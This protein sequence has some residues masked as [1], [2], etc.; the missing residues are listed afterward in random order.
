MRQL[1]EKLNLKVRSIVF[2]LQL[3]MLCLVSPTLSVAQDSDALCNDSR[4]QWEQSLQ[5]LKDGLSAFSAIQQTPA[6]QVVRRPLVDTR[7]AKSIALQI[8]EALQ[9]KEE[10]LNAKRKECRAALEKE[11]QTYTEYQNCLSQRGSKIK[12][13]EGSKLQKQRKA[14]VDKAL[15]TLAEVREVQGEDR[16]YAYDAMRQYQNPYGQRAN[17]YWQMYQGWWG[18]R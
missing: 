13:R 18:G 4:V 16:G 6:E 12:E 10:L 15:V 17:N 11:G 7:V 5:E 14:I 3:T 2:V 1:N 9:V 8:A